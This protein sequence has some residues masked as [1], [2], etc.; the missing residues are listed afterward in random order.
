MEQRQLEATVKAIVRQSLAEMLG[1][2]TSPNQP[3]RQWWRA[4]DAAQRLDLDT[5]DTLH[6]LRLAGDLIEGRHWRDISSRNAKRPTY[7]YHLGNCRTFLE[8]RRG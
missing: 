7:Q 6:D 3:Q 5:A 2:H 1:L 8:S 4:S